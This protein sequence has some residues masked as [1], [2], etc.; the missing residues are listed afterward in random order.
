MG[1]T[2]ATRTERRAA[3]TRQGILLAARRLFAEKGFTA[4]SITDIAAAA[5]VAVQTIYSRVGSKA[6]LVLA[7]V[8][9]MDA[10]AG[11]PKAVED[12]V[13]AADGL[14]V[15][16]AAVGFMRRLQEDWRDV[17]VALH[18]AAATDSAS[19]AALVEGR[20]RHRSGAALVAKRVAEV[21]PLRT[22]VSP[23]DAAVTI[24]LLTSYETFTLLTEAHGW[25]FARSEGWIAETLSRLIIEGD[26]RP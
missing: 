17:I 12:I 13:A 18:V 26:D 19:A 22:S 10:D 7:L 8:D 3:A 6:D 24:A 1:E 4:T 15:L 5:D 9:F 25:S 21:G 14:A 23:D 2:L 20:R 11:A 16:F